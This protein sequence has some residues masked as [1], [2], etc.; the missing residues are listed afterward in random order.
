M[1]SYAYTD[2]L[3][4]IIP[5]GSIYYRLKQV[6]FNGQFEYSPVRTV[7]LSGVQPVVEAY[8]NP[9]QNM[10]NINWT[11]QSQEPSTLKIVSITGAVLYQESVSGTGT[12]Q[13][14]LDL[15]G[16]AAGTYF[17][18]IISGDNL[19]SSVIYKK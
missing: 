1:N 18:Q 2:N 4:G 9:A 17:L 15:S 3:A 13:K 8:P 5:A 6:D 16:Y 19:S 14:Q 7:R 10:L 11:S 12:M